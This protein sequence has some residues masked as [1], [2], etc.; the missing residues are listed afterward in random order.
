MLGI[1][2]LIHTRNIPEIR[3]IDGFWWILNRLNQLLHSLRCNG[4]LGQKNKRIFTVFFVRLYL[5]HSFFFSDGSRFLKVSLFFSIS[6]PSKHL[7]VKYLT[8]ICSIVR[9]DLQV[10][11]ESENNLMT[12]L[13][14]VD[15]IG[16]AAGFLSNLTSRTFAIRASSS[17]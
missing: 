2:P 4:N 6:H 7:S 10:L 3:R 14:S 17:F 9:S 11:M 1:L 12:S 15:G 5:A 13:G 8:K 16:T